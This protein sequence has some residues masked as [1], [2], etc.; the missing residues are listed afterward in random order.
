MSAGDVLK[1]EICAH[2]QASGYEPQ[3]FL[4]F[5]QGSSGGGRCVV[6]AIDV[7]SPCPEQVAIKCIQRGS[8][9]KKHMIREVIYHR[10][11]VHKH[12]VSFKRVFL[13]PHHLC[14]V[15]T[16]A[17]DN[18]VQFW[19]NKVVCFPEAVARSLFQQMVCAVDFC[20]EKGVA[21]RDIKLENFLTTVKGDDS[22]S[23]FIIQLCD[24]GFSKGGAD[25]TPRT[26]AGTWGYISP[27]V[28][29]SVYHRRGYD[30]RAADV[31]SLGVCLY[32]LLYGEFPPVV[33]PSRAQ[34]T[35]WLDAE[36][37]RLTQLV[38]EIPEVQPRP[39]PNGEAA[40]GSIVSIQCRALLSRLLTADP[41]R[42][43]TMAGLRTDPWFLE[44][45]PADLVGYNDRL[46]GQYAN[47]ILH[48]QAMMLQD[49]KTLREMVEKAAEKP[50]MDW[51][52]GSPSSASDLS[53]F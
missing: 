33:A 42:R 47:H 26:L 29:Q 30:S 38:V 5:R 43:I 11:L 31:W 36:V 16:Y 19:L 39:A 14:I 15:M 17:P 46:R 49:E 3:D 18:T 52:I 27:E 22:T 48:E 32:R 2:L 28:V 10:D 51:A 21:N 34:S 37:R 6:R 44:D 9:S 45:Y 20:H 7:R 12:I 40:Q 1:Q 13:T 35:W 53:H 25:S 41:E 23:H 8:F 50:V 24:F 4:S